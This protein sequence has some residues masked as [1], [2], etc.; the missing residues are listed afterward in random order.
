MIRHMINFT[1][2][3]IVPVTGLFCMAKSND[4]N[5]KKEEKMALEI[6]NVAYPVPFA[7]F[8][9]NSCVPVEMRS[10]WSPLWSRKYI[11]IN[12]EIM[13]TPATVHLKENIVGV[14][15]E[16]DL[17]VYDTR[18]EFKYQLSLSG[19][20]EVIFGQR[21]MAFVSPSLQLTCQD[22]DQNEVGS[23]GV[24]PGL[25]DWA[26][27]LILK[28]ALDNVLA[29]VQFTGGPMRSPRK[30]HVY[31]FNRRDRRVNWY[32][33]Y[34]GSLDHALLTADGAKIVI[35]KQN[36]VIIFDATDGKT[37]HSFQTGVDLSLT[38]SLDLRDNL[39][40]L[41]EKYEE[42]RTEKSL[43]AFSLEGEALWSLALSA[44]QENQPPACGGGDRVY[45]IDAMLL[46]CLEKGEVKWTALLKPAEW[47]WITITRDNHAVVLNG[48][49]L[50][51]FDPAG[52]KVFE[53]LVT[54]TDE[55]FFAPPALNAEG[56]VL[57]AGQQTLYCFE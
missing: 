14:R 39:I 35:I 51:L 46:N 56:K 30:Y 53:R 29:V 18:G 23:P 19:G 13:I 3:V 55:E 32:Q 34:E 2:L 50:T 38:A 41:A 45:F 4:N 8:Q 44:P 36:Q 6:K 47:N 49:F 37:L 33:E 27:A 26:G 57:V 40:L 9:R 12:E 31:S 11:E 21:G 28:P 43:R 16:S 5:E 10:R 48:P 24:I 42:N 25:D 52:E 20:A 22:Y 54:K 17:L 15:S 1:L 7:N